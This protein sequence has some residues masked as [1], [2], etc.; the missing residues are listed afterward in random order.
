MILKYFAW[1]LAEVFAGIVAIT[2][3]H[4]YFY[5]LNTFVKKHIPHYLI[6]H[7]INYREK[8]SEIFSDDRKYNFLILFIPSIAIFVR[9]TYSEFM[10]DTFGLFAFSVA[11]IQAII[12]VIIAYLKFNKIK[13]QYDKQ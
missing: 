5:A 2:I 7:K 10:E 4:F 11:F 3:Y 1:F 9:T 13:E 8:L 12:T 6:D